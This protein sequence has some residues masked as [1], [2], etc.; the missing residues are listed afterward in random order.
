[1]SFLEAVGL[2][3]IFGDHLLHILS[4]LF[5]EAALLSRGNAA[6]CK[7]YWDVGKGSEG[8]R[9]QEIRHFLQRVGT[10]MGQLELW[11]G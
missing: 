11:L 1:M 7:G 4:S 3:R 10:R 2:L 6:T 9:E 8:S 5:L